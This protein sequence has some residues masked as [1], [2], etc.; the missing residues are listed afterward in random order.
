MLELTRTR[1]SKDET[2]TRDEENR[3][4][5]TKP[6]IGTPRETNEKTEG[7]Q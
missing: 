7:D 1:L 2:T 6:F 5:L 4:R 3:R